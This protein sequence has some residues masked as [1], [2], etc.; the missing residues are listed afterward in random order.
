ME[1][2]ALVKEILKE[3]AG[4]KDG[5]IRDDL[6]KTLSGKLNISEDDMV[7]QFRNVATNRRRL[8]DDQEG[9]G[10]SSVD[11][12]SSVQKAQ[13]E[14]IHALLSNDR[15][16]KNLVEENINLFTDSLLRGV[17]EKMLKLGMDSISA[18][19]ESIED[20]QDRE[21]VAGILMDEQVVSDPVANVTECIQT[22]KT[23]PIKDEIKETRLKIRDAESS[24]DDSSELIQKVGRL[25]AQLQN[26]SK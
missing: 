17:I 2:S 18:V 23:Q 4:I 22:L 1:R 25:Q 11:F 16:T 6:M 9:P 8:R 10:A 21:T 24:G 20:K 7:R 3:I 26:A 19:L 12:S 13:I 14:I 15:D 5:I